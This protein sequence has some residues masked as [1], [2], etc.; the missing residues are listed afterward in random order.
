R[1]VG[2][3]D[4]TPDAPAVDEI[5]RALHRYLGR[6]PSR[7]LAL[8]LADAVGDR[9]TQNQPGTTD[10]YPNWRVPLTGPDGH[11]LLVEDVLADPRAAALAEAMRE[12]VE[13]PV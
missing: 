13:P 4:D 3:L 9:R 2:L 8:S 1:R 12:A 10:E 6:S 11:N 7:L 5:V